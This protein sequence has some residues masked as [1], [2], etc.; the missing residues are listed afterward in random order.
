M[1][2]SLDTLSNSLKIALITGA[3]IGIGRITAIELARQGYK[4][5]LACRSPERTQPVIDEIKEITG[6]IDSVTFLHLELSDLVSVKKCAD[7][8]LSYNLPLHLLINNAGLAG[9]K[10][11]TSQGFELAFGVNH[12]GH[13][14][15]TKL[16]IERLKASEPARVVTVASR[17]H[18]LAT[19]G[20][21]WQ[22]LQLPTRSF[23]GTQEY[24]QSKLAN[25][26]FSSQ[27]SKNLINTG[28][29]TYSLHPGVVDTEVWRKVPQFLRPILRLRKMLTP[30]QGAQTTLFCALNA[31]SHE[32]G[33]YYDLSQIKVP[34]SHA[35]D[36]T[37]AIKLWEHS[38]QWT[39]PFQ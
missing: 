31:P 25:I 18:R 10:G 39:G 5:F 30:E 32:T 13:F 29:T 37:Q 17:A 26:L 28:V 12:L 3:N 38:M 15:L 21:S 9:A 11:I 35:L 6:K 16:L 19:N 34:T 27:L 20:I 22:T 7:A 23:T 1:K 2:L 24:A 36:E 8:F 14:L 4:L 33:L